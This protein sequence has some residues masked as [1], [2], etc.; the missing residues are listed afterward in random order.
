MGV[1][2]ADA[3]PRAALLDD[4]DLRAAAAA[5]DGCALVAGTAV[6]LPDG[7][8]PPLD[9]VGPADPALLPYTSGTTGTPKG[10]LLSHGNLLAS[11]EALRLAWRW[12]EDDCLILCLPLF[13][14]HGLGVGLHGTL[15]AGARAVLQSRFDARRRPGRGRRPRPGG[16]AVLRRPDDV[17]PAGRG[18]RS[19]RPAAGC[20]S[21]CP[22]SA[23]AQPPTSTP[24][25]PTGTG[26]AVL[27]RYGMTET[28][29][30]VSNPV[31]GER[32]PG[33]VGIPLPGVEVRLDPS[34]D[35]ILVRGPNVFAGYWQ[36]PDATA[37]A[38]TDD[39]WFRTGD[40]GAL[41]DDGYLA[42]VGRAK[43]LIITGGYNV[44][45][46]EVEDV[47][48]SHAGGRRRGGG[49]DA[50]R[51]VGRGR[52][53]LRRARRRVRRRGRAGLGRPPARAYKRP[54]L[55]HVVDALPR[56]AMGKVVRDRLVEP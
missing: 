44:Y 27:E 21:A 50:V 22:E 24:A 43:E 34:G 2:A 18:A 47:L 51:G 4:P 53:R 54:R 16:D 15:L 30:L 46:R 8:P 3:R 55:V 11:A 39:G 1:I 12:T 23:A 32:R 41:D 13:H 56:N 52:H 49:R 37:A 36:R 28:V 14:M 19:P 26:H 38:F 45:P 9:A 7:R 6:D 35:E 29:M 17:R 33:T 31:D 20:G 40:V 42:I 10:A 25:S 5:L 48:R